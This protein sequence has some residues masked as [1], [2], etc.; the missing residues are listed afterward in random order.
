[1]SGGKI[2]NRAD[3]FAP[4]PVVVIENPNLGAVAVRVYSW[5]RSHAPTWVVRVTDLQSRIHIKE[6][7][8]RRA[9][10]QLIAER[11]LIVEKYRGEKGRFEYIF[12]IQNPPQPMES[13]K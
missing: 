8:W 2:I 7:A 5:C 11:L 1:M 6:K 12:A 9:R 10:D 3:A 13:K 4:V